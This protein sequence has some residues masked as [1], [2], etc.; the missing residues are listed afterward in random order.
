MPRL[1][2]SCSDRCA[3]SEAH[4]FTDRVFDVAGVN[5]RDDLQ[6]LLVLE[7]VTVTLLVVERREGLPRPV[8]AGFAAGAVPGCCARERGTISAPPRLSNRQKESKRTSS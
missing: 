1:G 6:N 2:L 4:Q 7:G 5:F 8:V 3:G